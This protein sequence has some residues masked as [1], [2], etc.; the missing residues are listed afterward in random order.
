M[1]SFEQ[2]LVVFSSRVDLLILARFGE[3]KNKENPYSFHLFHSLLEV[4]RVFREFLLV[5]LGLV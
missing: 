5:H 2:A 1:D 4:Q 3:Q